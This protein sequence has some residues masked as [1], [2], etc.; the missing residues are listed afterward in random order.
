M[1]YKDP[2]KQRAAM[3]RWRDKHPEYMRKYYRDVTKIVSPPKTARTHR[4]RAGV[5]EEV[6]V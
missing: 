3:K 6:E 5:L 2:K 1:A 4:R